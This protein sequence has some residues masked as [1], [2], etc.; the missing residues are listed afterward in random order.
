MGCSICLEDLMDPEK[1]AVYP[2]ACKG[3]AHGLHGE[4]HLEWCKSH[5]N[6]EKCPVC[7]AGPAQPLS[8]DSA[9]Y[10]KYYR[11][12]F[13]FIAGIRLEGYIR[14]VYNKQDSAI[15]KPSIMK[16]VQMLSKSKD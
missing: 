8:H 4:C 10:E 12:L 16:Y 1:T 3:K 7:R 9:D 15:T 6:A 2:F 14:Y 5:G 11:C 13:K